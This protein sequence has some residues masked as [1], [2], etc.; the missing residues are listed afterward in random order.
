MGE[1]T[2]G[3]LEGSVVHVS[4]AVDDGVMG[5]PLREVRGGWL[6]VIL[7]FGSVDHS[8]ECTM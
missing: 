2:R 7:L 6:N 3:A 8:D 5:V 4:A 1:A